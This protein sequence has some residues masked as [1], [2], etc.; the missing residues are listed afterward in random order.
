MKKVLIIVGMI[1]AMACNNAGDSNAAD[2]K[3]SD[4]VAGELSDPAKKMTLPEKTA[5]PPPVA[6]VYSGTLP[7]ESCAELAVTLTLRSDSTFQ[8]NSQYMGG[9]GVTGGTAKADTGIWM[10][11]GDTLMLALK[12]TNEKYLKRDREL[13]LLDG[14]TKIK[15]A[16]SYILK[17]TN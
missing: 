11:R 7:C 10:M 8:K 15:K 2:K 14:K 13:T 3:A 9:S 6:A 5:A 16:G 12:K 1:T 17:Q 4:S